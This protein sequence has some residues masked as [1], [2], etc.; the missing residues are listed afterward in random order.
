MNIRDIWQIL[1]DAQKN[2]TKEKFNE[3]LE[4]DEKFILM[5]RKLLKRYKGSNYKP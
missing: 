2:N 3:L 1:Y 4:K 5:K